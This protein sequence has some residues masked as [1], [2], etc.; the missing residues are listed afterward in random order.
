MTN[1][2]S[3]HNEVIDD[4]V[5]Y[6]NSSFYG[7]TLAF[8]GAVAIFFYTAYHH[9][10]SWKE[11]EDGDNF[12]TLNLSAFAPPS[13]D[14]IAEEIQ[15]P[16]PQEHKKEK[17]PKKKEEIQ[18]PPKDE[19][20]PYQAQ[21]EV[22]KETEVAKDDTPTPE[23]AQNEVKPTPDDVK[24]GDRATTVQS[25]PDA[26]STQNIKVMRY[27]EGVENAF[28]KAIRAAIEKRHEYPNLARQRG[29]EGEVLVKFLIDDKGQ[30]S[31]IQ[32]VRTSKHPILDKAAVKTLKRACRDFPKPD[33]TTFIEIPIAYVLTRG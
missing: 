23:V 4:P 17:K 28:L 21:Q 2:E 6:K 18:A 11:K 10:E 24:E 3:T 15:K 30:V 32:V 9:S 25:S 20:A 8:V 7:G 12:V 16:K 29:Y 14:P 27:S 33:E 22:V 1:L 26:N 31:H 19:P 13:N 5:F